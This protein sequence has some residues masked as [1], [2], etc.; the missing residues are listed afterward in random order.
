MERGL[1]EFG[2]DGIFLFEAAQYCA[3]KCDYERAVAFYEASYAAEADKKPR[4]CD[5]LEGIAVIH[6]IR[7]DWEKAAE[8]RDRI[9]DNM[10]NEW[11]LDPE[12]A[13]VREA[14]AEKNRVMKKAGR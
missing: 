3:R 8:A 6:E 1:S 13:A 12:S 4:Y 11:G 10:L 2:E 5:A 9:L 7:G 14:E